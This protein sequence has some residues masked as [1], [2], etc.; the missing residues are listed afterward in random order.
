MAVYFLAC[1]LLALTI[2]SWPIEQF[3]VFSPPVAQYLP[4]RFA[5][6]VNAKVIGT[7][8]LNGVPT[9]ITTTTN[10]T[11]VETFL[12][13]LVTITGKGG[14][15]AQNELD[16]AATM[17]V[18]ETLLGHKVSSLILTPLGAAPPSNSTPTPEGAMIQL[19]IALGRVS[20]T[21]WAT[22]R[23]PIIYNQEGTYYMRISI[24]N[25]SAVS[26]SVLT[27]SPETVTV[28]AR[29]NSLIVSLTWAILLFAVLELRKD[30]GYTYKKKKQ[31]NTP[32]YS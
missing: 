10:E 1:V 12:K 26:S 3:D 27:V 17:T 16:L 5:D 6:I 32:L 13:G 28:T 25:Y 31:K 2:F 29:T 18:N 20:E 11:I 7:L 14:I 23:I 19:V 15:S 21:T 24:D 30:E 22:G 9:N 4:V 8:V